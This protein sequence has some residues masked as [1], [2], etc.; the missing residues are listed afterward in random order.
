MIDLKGF[1]PPADCPAPGSCVRIERPEAGLA[2]VVLDPPHRSLAVLDYPLIRDLDAAVDELE[3]EDGLRGVVITGRN[4][5]QF[6]AGADVHAIQG[7]EDP[8]VVQRVV[9]E[10]H[11]LFLRIQR[12]APRTVAAV[13]G[14]VPGG[15]YELALACDRIVA[16]DDSKTRIGLPE[17]LLG[18]LPGW[19]GSHRLP[20][21]VGV[22]TALNAILTGRL[23]PARQAKKLGMVDRL[24]KPEY[25]ERIAADIAMGRKPCARYE[26]GWKSWGVDAN[27]LAIWFIERKAR[28]Q[29]E[30]KTKGH[31]PAPPAALEL[32]IEAPNTSMEEAVEKEAEALGRLAT[33][34]VCKNLISIFLAS[35]DA[36]KLG[37]PAGGV[38]PRK[39][40]RAGVIGAG[41]MGGGIA[42]LLA[43]K[44]VAVRLADLSPEALDA[45]LV[46]HRADVEK[47][48]RRR[49]LER[50]VVNQMIDHLDGATEVAG[51]Q[52]A[53]L[54]VEAVAERLEVK[55]AVFQRVAEQ[56]G[57][58]AILATNTSSLSVDAIASELPHPERVAG[59]HFFNPVKKMPLV[60]I[61][62]GAKTSEEVVSTIAALTVRLGKTPVVVKDVAGFLVNRLLGPY[63]D[64]A[65]RMFVGGAEI[66][67]IDRLMERFGMPMGPFRLLDEVGL[68]IAAHAAESLHAAYG[69]RMTPSTGL[70]RLMSPERLGK[71]TGKGFYRHPRGKKKSKPVLCDDLAQFQED[72]WGRSLS[73]EQIVDRLVLA[74]VN[75]AARC[76]E[77]EVVAG[78]TE[79]DLAT[80]FGTGFAPFRGGLLRYADTLGAKALQDKLS[81]IAARPEVSARP[82]GTPKFA[83]CVLIQEM[84]AEGRSF[85]ED[86]PAPEPGPPETRN[87]SSTPQSGDNS[88]RT[89]VTSPA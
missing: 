88:K 62:R 35:E 22:P 45:A 49:R 40:E 63:L 16:T 52:R 75:E 61:V 11:K 59:M 2:V 8:A 89:A 6:A 55:Q 66:E 85:H 54:V 21:R 25:L 79:L 30:Q 68:D 77:E 39:I 65:V 53:Q 10:V 9:R 37:R 13:G 34:S 44:G 17:T 4:P 1:T 70:E 24:T 23:F 67:R 82:G 28:E 46:E 56:A 57:K 81:A 32:V 33:S 71:K 74:M 86:E 83:P 5:G 80:V 72:T 29:V 64:E 26:R 15:A 87:G 14:P 50:H 7:I 12:M 42:S 31:Y 69:E 20:K 76:L 78:A 60:E 84:A 43:Q 41:V 38:D 51:F 48:R 3:N 58:D 19:G 47:K 27:P 73:D 36:K 18:I